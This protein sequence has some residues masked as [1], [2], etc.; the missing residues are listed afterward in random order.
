MN[1]RN[2]LIA[3][4]SGIFGARIPGETVEKI[5]FAF[6]GDALVFSF[7]REVARGTLGESQRDVGSVD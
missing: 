6:V 4:N 2:P 7:P 5:V 3:A 1:P